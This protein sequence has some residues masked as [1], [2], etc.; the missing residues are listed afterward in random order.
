MPISFLMFLVSA[1]MGLLFVVMSASL[2]AM[3]IRRRK[4]SL[5]AAFCVVP[6]VAMLAAA[7]VAFHV[8]W[9][10]T[11]IKLPPGG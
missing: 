8:A 6:A 7:L 3:G 11:T 5:L 4:S 2:L 10:M 9:Q 1:T